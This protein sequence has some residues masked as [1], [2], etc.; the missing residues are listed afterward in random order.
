MGEQATKTVHGVT[1]VRCDRHHLWLREQSCVQSWKEGHR[2]CSPKQLAGTCKDCGVG[3]ARAKLAANA[4]VQ[5]SGV[6]K[7]RQG[8][9]AR[10]KPEC[11]E[12]GGWRS[13]RVNLCRSCA[14]RRA[15][16]RRRAG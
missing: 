11:V 2:P 16:K 8:L 13:P 14:A 4:S 15:W 9:W 10:E 6:D 5:D 7:R 3:E 1:L 12:C